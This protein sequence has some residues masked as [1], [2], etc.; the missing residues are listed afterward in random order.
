[1][2]EI[3]V[4]VYRDRRSSVHKDRRFILCNCSQF[5]DEET[6]STS[7]CCTIKNEVLLVIAYLQLH[8]VSV[9]VLLNINLRTYLCKKCVLYNILRGL[10]YYLA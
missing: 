7:A 8:I 10:K 4:C 6:E 1:M 9:P 3:D 5:I 2:I